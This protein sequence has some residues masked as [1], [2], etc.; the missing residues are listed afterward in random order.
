MTLIHRGLDFEQIMVP[1]PGEDD[2]ELI[3]VKVDGAV[4]AYRNRC[5]H[6][7]VGLDYGD[8]RC[9]FDGMLECA[10]H[11]ARFRPHD[12]FCVDGPCRGQG[13]IPVAVEVI[14]DDI[15]LS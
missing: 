4:R 9:L 8:G 7:G 10:M 11:A 6:L 13:L 14:G 2:A 5:P 15:R 12:G 1:M 3:L